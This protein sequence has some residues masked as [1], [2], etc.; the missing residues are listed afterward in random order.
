MAAGCTKTRRIGTEFRARG[1]QLI[2]AR[3]VGPD[4]LPTGKALTAKESR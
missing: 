2:L 3:D 1:A 4:Y